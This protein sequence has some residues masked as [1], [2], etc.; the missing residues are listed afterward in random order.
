MRAT[1]AE[2]PTEPLVLRPSFDAAALDYLLRKC[3]QAII[4]SDGQL[5]VR[6]FASA[7][8]KDS[9]KVAGRY[10]G[11]E[12]RYAFG[13][14]TPGFGRLY[15]SKGVQGLRGEVRRQLFDGHYVELDIVN[16]SPSLLELQL[17]AMAYDGAR[18][19]I[20]Y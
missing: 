18:D 10:E 8:K 2:L 17:D 7:V 4:G 9:R 14:M 15:C 6:T 19:A 11:R 13:S 16:C 20:D 3:P 12:E 1:P 5:T